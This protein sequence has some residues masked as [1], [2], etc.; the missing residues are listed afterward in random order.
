MREENMIAELLRAF[1]RSPEQ[2]NTPHSCDAEL[3]TIGDA[4]WAM[5]IDEF[6]P[7]EDLFTSEDPR[8]L[9][10]N[11]ATATLS[12]LLAAG[13]EPRF[14]LQAVCLPKEV[15]PG[16]LSGLSAGISE[17]LE[18]AGCFLCGGDIG[19]AGTWRFCGTAMG[20]VYDGRPI[21]RILGDAQGAPKDESLLLWVTGSLGD[22]NLAALTGAPT[23]RLELRTDEA[24]TMRSCALACIDT[25]GGFADAIW[26][27][28]TMNPGWRFCVDCAALPLG[29]ELT[30]L[31]GAAELP[32]EAALLGGAGE[33]ELVFVTPHSLQAAKAAEFKRLGISCIG[34]VERSDEPG[35]VFRRDRDEAAML[36]P[37]PCARSAATVEDHVGEVL[38]MAYALFGSGAPCHG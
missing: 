10:A 16:F 28:K 1:P 2:H 34:K 27:L 36:E 37:P 21:M 6:S 33:Y 31:A 3:V 5:T 19:G 18:Q 9:G 24:R 15:P 8:I 11:L 30:A 12:D 17:V 32:A 29:S 4:L 26:Q 38:Q 7:E 35:I 25:S 23:P 14:F 20:P 22:A 13:A